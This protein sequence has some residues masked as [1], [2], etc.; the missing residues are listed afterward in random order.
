MELPV[1]VASVPPLPN[2]EHGVKEMPPRIVSIAGNIKNNPTMRKYI[3]LSIFV[4][5]LTS[6]KK[7]VEV[8]VKNSED[9]PYIGASIYISDIEYPEIRKYVDI[10][11]QVSQQ[12]N[13]VIGLITVG[14]TRDEAIEKTKES[15]TKYHAENPRSYKYGF[16]SDDDRSAAYKSFLEASMDMKSNVTAHGKTNAMGTFRVKLPNKDHYIFIEDGQKRYYGS[17]YQL[18]TQVYKLN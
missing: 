11:E 7:E 18:D 14:L 1:A 17:I 9:R 4:M 10:V 2:K 3:F 16:I 12:N 15:Y 8:I 6:C 13:L 5:A